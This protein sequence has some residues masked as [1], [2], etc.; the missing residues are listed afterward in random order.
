MRKLLALATLTTALMWAVPASAHHS[1][2]AEFDANKPVKLKGKLTQLEWLNPHGWLHI[3]VTEPDGKVVNWAIEAGAPNAL[4]RRG[5]R[6]T[7]FPI[8][9]EVVVEGYRAKD[10]KPRASGQT[11]TFADGRNFFLGAS[12]AQSQAPAAPAR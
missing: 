1:F 5:L 11:V 2:A 9:S 10:D 7:D 3:D 8:G 6:K 12:D 4:I